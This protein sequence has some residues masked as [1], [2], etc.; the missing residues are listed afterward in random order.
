M[1]NISTAD[2]SKNAQDIYNFLTTKLNDLHDL[3]REDT[4]FTALILAPGN[5]KVKVVY[6]MGLVTAQI[7][8]TPTTASKLL[9]L[10]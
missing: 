7:V 10:Y 9:T 5:Q 1:D 3:N 8:K 6:D 2:Q 4:I